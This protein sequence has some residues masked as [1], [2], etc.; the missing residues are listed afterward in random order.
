MRPA[1]FT[2]WRVVAVA[3]D[4]V[5]TAAALGSA[6][7]VAFG[8][9]RA[10]ELANPVRNTGFLTAPWVWAVPIWIVTF[11][12]FG[13]YNPTRW[14]NAVEEARRL[15]AAGLAAPIAFVVGAFAAGADPS[16][17]WLAA[18]TGFVL[19]GAGM[20]RRGLRWLVEDM[21]RAGR[22]LTPIVVCGRTEAKAVV[23]SL[24]MDR[25]AGLQP[26]A[27]CGF[28]WSGLPGYDLNDLTRAVGDT[29]AGGVVVVAE[30]LE[31]A[32]VQRAVSVL[33][34]MPAT[35]YV[36]P[37]LDYTLANSLQIVPV[38]R[39]PGL[40]LEAPALRPYQR[41]LKR[42]MDVVGSV[43]G[44]LVLAPLF[45]V[46]ALAIRLDS[47]G[48][49][50]FRQRRAGHRGNVL[51]I[52]K[53]RTMILGADGLKD[54]LRDRNET[55]GILFKIRDDPRVT[56]VGRFLRRFS[57]DE[58]PQLWNVLSGNMSLI[59]PRPLP[60][61]DYQLEGE[62]LALRRRLAVRPGITG[63]WQIRGR[64]ELGTEDL[65]RLDLTYVQ[66]WSLL[67]DCYVLL[68]TIPVVLIGRGAH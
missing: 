61:D 35:V 43:F 51:E 11:A 9:L 19:V 2:P 42:G 17:V 21:R 63:L 56:R 25:S 38:G 66:S 26:V 62:R 47:P 49:V 15:V 32:E 13:L 24:L 55:D 34:S 7:V 3:I 22:W 39:E 52:L 10:W 29:K 30:D 65:V 68:R 59:G 37:G 23:D 27:V 31:R 46:V 44:L 60:I 28:D 33:D 53:F 64:S 18:G 40:A 14:A 12:V 20:G 67:L 4:T 57:I 48:P 8:P 16:R 50:L 1:W 5:A 45:A 54:E 6:A 41:A 36:L 58:L